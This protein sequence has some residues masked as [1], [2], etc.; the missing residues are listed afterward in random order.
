MA[1]GLVS[2]VLKARLHQLLCCL[3]ELESWRPKWE[4]QL[5]CGQS[6]GP[7][8]GS[9]MV[10]LGGVVLAPSDKPGA[11]S[12]RMRSAIRQHVHS[13]SLGSIPKEGLRIIAE[14]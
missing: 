13:G 4:G 3:S 7:D 1:L 5:V 9:A 8:G 10:V 6:S 2:H 11:T 14:R 12:A